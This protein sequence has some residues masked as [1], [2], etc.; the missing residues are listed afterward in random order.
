MEVI[1]E[2]EA[3]KA[4]RKFFSKGSDFIE[5]IEISLIIKTKRNKVFEIFLENEAGL[6]PA[7]KS[8]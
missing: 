2:G 7:K 1:R 5:S 6:R 8:K 3:E 4:L